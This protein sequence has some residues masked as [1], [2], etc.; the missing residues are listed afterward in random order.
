[1]AEVVRNLAVVASRIE[2]GTVCALK[3]VSDGCSGRNWTVSRLEILTPVEV[4]ESFILVVEVEVEVRRQT[5]I[6]MV[7]SGDVD[8][9][10]AGAVDIIY[11][12]SSSVVFR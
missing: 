5:P 10:Q 4:L 6:P 12:E 1:M 3:A 11:L 9:F 7:A 2:R 8:T